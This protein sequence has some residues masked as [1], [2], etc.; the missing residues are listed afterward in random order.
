MKFIAAI[1]LLLLCT[2]TVASQT[3]STLKRQLD[4]ITAEDQRYREIFIILLDSLKTDSLA[5][6]YHLPATKLEEHF[7][8]LQSEIDSLN[9]AFIEAVI[10]KYG[11]PGKSMVGEPANETAWYVIQHSDKISTYF[12]EIQKAGKKKELSSV[13][14]AM[15]EDRLLVEQNRKQKYGSQIARRKMKG[16]SEEVVFVWPIKQAST[17]NKRRQKI[18]FKTTVEENAKRF[19]IEYEKIKLNEIE[20]LESN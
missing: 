1:T 5:K 2:G 4:S 15:M 9:L 6:A 19:H 20:H 17:V 11:Y 14:V 16:G 8:S 18:G 3:N 10:A 12:K 7:S 13:L